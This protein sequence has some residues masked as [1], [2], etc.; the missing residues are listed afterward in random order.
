MVPLNGAPINL[1]GRLVLDEFVCLYAFAPTLRIYSRSG[2]IAKDREP[3]LRQAV[4]D[5]RLPASVPLGYDL[6]RTD[7]AWRSYMEISA[8]TGMPM[9]MFATGQFTPNSHV[10]DSAG[11]M[12]RVLWMARG[13][14]PAG[15]AKWL[16][17]VVGG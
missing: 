15:V 3:Q 10:G 17:S 2:Q 4:L 12:I 11:R 6:E 8:G 7:K 14:P 16:R 5:M 9:A 13:L 1:K